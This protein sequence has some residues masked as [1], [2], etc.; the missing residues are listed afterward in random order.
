MKFGT[1]KSLIIKEIQ[2]LFQSSKVFLYYLYIQ[3]THTPFKGKCISFYRSEVKKSGT[4]EHFN[5][6]PI[7][8]P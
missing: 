5:K 7:S 1:Q 4:L 8:T 6:Y 2:A 3:Y